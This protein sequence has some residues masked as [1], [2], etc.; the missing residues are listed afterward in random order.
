MRE[1][2]KESKT[3]MGKAGIKTPEKKKKQKKKKKKGATK[4]ATKRVR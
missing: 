1:S 2:N 4:K 3:E